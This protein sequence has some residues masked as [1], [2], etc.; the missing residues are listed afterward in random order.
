MNI[1]LI[2]ATG[3]LGQTLLPMALA[4]GHQVTVFVRNASKLSTEQSSKVTVIE[5]DVFNSERLTEACKH[6]D[7]VINTAGNIKD[8]ESYAKLFS[9]VLQAAEAGMGAG[10]RF[11]CCGGAAVLDVPGTDRMTV[12]FP[13]V[14]ALFATHQTNFLR[15]KDTL[16][17]WS[18]ACPGPMIPSSNGKPHQGLRISA[19]VWPISPAKISRFLPDIFTS[20]AFKRIMP[21]LTVTYEDTASVILSN[22][23]QDSSLCK[24]R[25]GI[26][27]PPG[28]QLNK[29][30]DDLTQ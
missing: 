30:I 15:L 1:L 21:E 14:P 20:L 29:N 12:S 19:N 5:G 16:L 17:N 25:V 4:A 13:K 10:G 8:G 26:A 7:V 11:W 3:S 28:T 9:S 23:N 18:M 27:L 2:G 24:K 6:Q 22:L